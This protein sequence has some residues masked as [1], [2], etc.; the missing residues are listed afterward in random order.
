MKIANQ[1]IASALE[2]GES[3]QLDFVPQVDEIQ[4]GRIICG[5]LNTKGGQLIIGIDEQKNIL[6]VK[7]AQSELKKLKSLLFTELLPEPAVSLNLE[8][9]GNKNLIAISVWEGIHPPYIFKGNIYF[10]EGPATVRATSRQLADLI[11]GK[12]TRYTHWE[13]RPL[14]EASMDDL[15]LSDVKSC[16]KDIKESGQIV[17][18]S[19]DPLAFL[20]KYNLYK[21]GDL[22]HAAILLFGKEPVKFFPQIRVR[23]SVFK[24]DKA[25]DQILY[26]RYFEKNLFR[27]VSDITDFFDL[28]YGISSSFSSDAW[29]RADKLR[30]PR[31]AIREAII[32]AFIHRDYSFYSGLV[33]INI[34]PDKL[35]ISNNGS[36]PEGWSVET[37]LSEHTSIPFNPK[38]AHIF[39]LRQWIELIGRGPEKMIKDCYNA[40]IAKPFWRTDAK[41]IQVTFPGLR[42]PFNATEGISEG[43]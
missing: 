26:D 17:D 9:V 28:A 33:F 30:Y 7:N 40:G 6:G 24:T 43:I 36:L 29:Q 2:K 25:G 16:V 42:V 15:E 27:N 10:R 37:L 3:V 31:Q 41:T 39:Y 18:L 35:T 5:L 13:L 21:N 23:L 1:Y 22:T 20:A 8:K 38:I 12:D 32:N 19:D 34:F 11:H 4:I 14:L